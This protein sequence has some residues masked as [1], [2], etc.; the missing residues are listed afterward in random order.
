M[1]ECYKK[2][3]TNIWE[4]HSLNLNEFLTI[5]GLAYYLWRT[6]LK[7]KVHLMSY[8]NDQWVRRAIFG[9]RC[10]PQKQYYA[11]PDAD[12]PYDVITDYLV[13][14]DVVSLYPTAMKSR[15]PDFPDFDFRYPDGHF[16]PKD[17]I[18]DE[19]AEQR[20]KLQ[21]YRTLF[22]EH[23]WS[24]LCILE[25]ELELPTHL[26]SAPLPHKDDFGF[27]RW[28]FEDAAKGRQVYTS[29]DINRAIKYGYRIKK[30][31]KMLIFHRRLHGSLIK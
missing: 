13:D 27:T 24:K 15:H 12:K 26:I 3:A 8:E 31:H 22:N 25:V 5:S 16:Y 7:E 6:M 14:L 30:I 18:T 21:T 10:Y 23:G 9:G 17:L 1:R 29:V 4:A 11:S 20:R 19:T 28:S 2:I